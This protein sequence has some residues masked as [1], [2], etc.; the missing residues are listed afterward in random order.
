MACNVIRP[1]YLKLAAGSHT[2]F[3]RLTDDRQVDV[4]RVLHQRIDVDRHL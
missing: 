1:G 4:V 3:Y 2:L